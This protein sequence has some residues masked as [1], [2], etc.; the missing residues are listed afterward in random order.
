MLA[1]A[2]LRIVVR[3]RKM[4]RRRCPLQRRR[5][6][7]IERRVVPIEEGEAFIPSPRVGVGLVVL[8]EEGVS[9]SEEEAAEILCLQ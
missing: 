2:P 9:P 7:V 5:L 6:G 3:L 4:A 1:A 8:E